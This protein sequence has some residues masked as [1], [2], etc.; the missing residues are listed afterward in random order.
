MLCSLR[1]SSPSTDPTGGF[2]L[3]ARA[4]TNHQ[5]CQASRLSLTPDP[6]SLST[7]QIPHVRPEQ[8]LSRAPCCT[9]DKISP[10]LGAYQTL[11]VLTCLDFQVP[12]LPTGSSPGAGGASAFVQALLPPVPFPCLPRAP[13]PEAL[14]EPS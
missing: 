3:C 10:H 7:W 5:H 13:F 2:K 4:F 6:L 12:L 14:Q 1:S 11:L 9:G 8:S